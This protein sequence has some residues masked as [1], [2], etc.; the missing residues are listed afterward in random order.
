LISFKD[1]TGEWF[2][3]F[4]VLWGRLMGDEGKEKQEQKEKEEGKSR[5]RTRLRCAP[6]EG[7]ERGIV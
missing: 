5:L 3:G 7:N 6:E 1:E 4:V 2:Y